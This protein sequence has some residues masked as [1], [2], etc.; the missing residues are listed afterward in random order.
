MQ[1][2][3]DNQAGRMIATCTRDVRGAVPQGR[4]ESHPSTK[5]NFT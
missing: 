5:R 4:S 1:H 3:A 2:G